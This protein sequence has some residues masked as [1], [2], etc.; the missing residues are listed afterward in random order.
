MELGRGGYGQVYAVSSKWVRKVQKRAPADRG[1]ST[2]A[3]RE[4]CMIRCIYP[5][6]H[7]GPAHLSRDGTCTFHMRRYSMSLIDLLR[8]ESP[9]PVDVAVQLF[10]D[11][12]VTLRAAHSNHIMHRDIKPENIMVEV[13]AHGLS[14][15]LIDWGMARYTVG[16]PAHV[17]GPWTPG[18]TTI[19]YRAPELLTGEPYGPAVDVWSLGVLAVELLTGRCPFRGRTELAQLQNYIE[20]LGVPPR[21]AFRAWP[22]PVHDT[23]LPAGEAEPDRS[24]M[25]AVVLDRVRGAAGLI[26][27]MVRWTPT[28]RITLEELVCHP[29]FE[30]YGA[31]VDNGAAPL[32]ITP[33][34]RGGSAVATGKASHPR[35]VQRIVTRLLFPMALRCGTVEG[36]V[37]WAA[38]LFFSQCVARVA[39]GSMHQARLLGVACMDIANKLLGVQTEDVLRRAGI[40]D[41]CS[42]EV[43]ILTRV[44]GL[45]GVMGPVQDSPVTCL[46]QR[47]GGDVPQQL[48]TSEYRTWVPRTPSEAT[49]AY[50]R[51]VMDACLLASPSAVLTRPALSWVPRVLQTASYACSAASQGK[52]IPFSRDILGVAMRSPSWC[53][54][55]AWAARD[56]VQDETRLRKLLSYL[57]R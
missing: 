46:R 36:A 37:L 39:I 32:P 49:Y 21:N 44:L 29:F 56:M 26:D 10:R 27:R 15:R 34:V 57:L 2:A 25:W 23:C 1:I 4:L 35:L 38:A 12:V 33:I 24:D 31:E 9:L 5:Q 43:T 50:S 45:G 19:W 41:A 52:T 30:R 51:A 48:T 28:E 47:F 6:S 14:A 16:T 11:L 7:L 22:L 18:V 13:K 54:M 40:T 17:H 55:H 42:A 8:R 20:V 3:L 53:K